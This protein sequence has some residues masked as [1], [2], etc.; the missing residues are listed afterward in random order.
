[1]IVQDSHQEDSID[2]GTRHTLRGS[3]NTEHAPHAETF[4]QG[5][6][7]IVE[8]DELR[9]AGAYIAQNLPKIIASLA[10]KTGKPA[11]CHTGALSGK[12]YLASHG[13]KIR[14]LVFSSSSPF[15]LIVDR[16]LSDAILCHVFGGILETGLAEQEEITP[17]EHTYLT[18]LALQVLDLL[19]QSDTDFASLDSVPG[20]ASTACPPDFSDTDM[21]VTYARIVLPLSENLTTYFDIVRPCQAIQ[22]AAQEDRAKPT[23]AWQQSLNS[24]VQHLDMHVRARF[25]PRNLRFSRMASLSVGDLLD[26]DSFDTLELDAGNHII[27]HGQLGA[28][29]EYAALKIIKINHSAMG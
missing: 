26:M 29:D 5:L 24:A 28:V 6:A 19:N 7:A 15:Y 2:T 17:S 12:P 22:S 16:L 18:R 4:P 11:T 23:A 1:M 20:Q 8:Y 21:A 27:A 14:C 13:G 9:Q 25:S 10:D 3:E